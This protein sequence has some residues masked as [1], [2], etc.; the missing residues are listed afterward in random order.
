MTVS[1]YTRQ[2]QAAI[3]A[4]EDRI[5]NITDLNAE[6]A[7]GARG[8]AIT[9]S[10]PTDA[11]AP[12]QAFFAV[13]DG[14]GGAKS[15]IHAASHLHANLASDP[16]QWR[17]DPRQALATAFER[18]EAELRR[19]YEKSVSDGK[20]ERSGTCGCAA[21][22]RGRRLLVAWV[23]DCRALLLRHDGHPEACV[24]LT[25]DHRATDSREM[26]R[27]VKAG[28]EISDGR[29][30]GSLMPSRT[31]GDFPWKTKPGLI[32]EPEI[33]E[34]E[35]GPDDKYLI[36]GSDG[37]FDVLSNKA[38]AKIGCKMNSAAQKVC[39]ELVK[40]FRKKP[41]SDDCSIIVVQLATH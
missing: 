21:V 15:A 30:W 36:F 31:L 17:M 23:G 3:H 22:L 6:L 10:A 40:E 4:N 39:N 7:K 9:A 35:L 25:S 1:T 12:A 28:G 26:S 27:V 32:A 20:E 41:S 38:I 29:V 13:Y 16:V 33:T 34:I 24:Q 19:A 18:T 37:L 5:T 2:G 14:H 8:A 11:S